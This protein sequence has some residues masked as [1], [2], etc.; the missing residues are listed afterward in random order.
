MYRKRSQLPIFVTYCYQSHDLT[1]KKE[2]KARTRA[3]DNIIQCRNGF[4]KCIKPCL[5]HLSSDAR[6]W[7]IRPPCGQ[8]VFNCLSALPQL[9]IFIFFRKDYFGR[10][11]YCPPTYVRFRKAS[12]L[13]LGEISWQSRQC[14]PKTGVHFGRVVCVQPLSPTY[15]KDDDQVTLQELVRS[16]IQWLLLL[17]T[18]STLSF[19]RAIKFKFLL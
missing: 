1:K 16:N 14:A 13:Q 7:A 3:A 8:I 6:L 12:D 4:E 17:W 9:C 5:R 2:K 11:V 18:L 15:P 10:S 19:P